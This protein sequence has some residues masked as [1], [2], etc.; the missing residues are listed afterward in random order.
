MQMIKEMTLAAFSTI[1]IAILFKTPKRASLY[2]GLI[3]SISWGVFYIGVDL[4][5]NIIASSF[6]GAITVGI[7][8][9]I[10]A[11]KT[12]KPATL[13]VNPGIISLV[14]GA[15]MYNTMLALIEV[16]YAAAFEKGSETFFIAA[17]IAMGIIVSSVFSKSIKRVQS[18]I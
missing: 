13:Y 14:P 10:F 7:L 2:G 15:G 6:L 16:D 4:T 3:G 1:G 12:K 8:G 11:R 17:A 18:K 5:N 9:E